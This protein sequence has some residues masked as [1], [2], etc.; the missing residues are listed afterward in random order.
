MDEPAPAS[1]PGGDGPVV[2]G[3]V[4]QLSVLTVVLILAG[5]LGAMGGWALGFIHG[6]AES[7]QSLALAAQLRPDPAAAPAS[8]LEAFDRLDR[9]AQAA[10][11][12]LSVQERQWLVLL[13]L[14]AASRYRVD[15]ELA[16]SVAVA[17]SGL[18]QEAVSARGAIGIMQV[19]P[20]T[21]R[22]YGANPY[23]VIQNIE[24]GVR[25]LADLLERYRG[26]VRLALAAYNA[27]PSRVRD[28]VPA[29]RET[30]N[31]VRRV[32]EAY[33]SRW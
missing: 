21:A 10:R 33:R 3:Q 1:W 13:L 32:V 30:R 9:R 24:T 7:E 8:W 17:E 23:D 25:Y 6:Y 29:I 22:G 5:V 28:T 20:A 16:M 27:G 12:D 19:M 26:D 31:Y 11:P 18:R 2:A 4:R 14:R 15:P